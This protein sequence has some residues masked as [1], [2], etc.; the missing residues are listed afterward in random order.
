[1]WRDIGN[2]SAATT[3]GLLWSPADGSAPRPLD[4]G[5]RQ[6]RRAMRLFKSFSPYCRRPSQEPCWRLPERLEPS[7]LGE[8]TYEI[9]RRNVK[10][11]D[12]VEPLVRNTLDAA[13]RRDPAG[14]ET[15]FSRFTSPELAQKGL[16]LATAICVFILFEIHEGKPSSQQIDE[17][18]ADIQRQEEWIGSSAEEVSTFLKAIADHQP[19]ASVLPEASMVVLP[20]LIAANLL[21]TSAS[22]EE[23]EWWFKYLDKVEAAIEA[24]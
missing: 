24:A 1:M 10:I 3:S 4:G 20:Y 21:T 13:V 2:R 7:R 5:R 17:L 22:P 16:E 6:R 14:L 23:G 18:S 11:N 8:R 15:A 19:V 12:R 9:E